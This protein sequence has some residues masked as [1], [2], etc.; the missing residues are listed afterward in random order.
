MLVNTAL[1]VRVGA[2][3][4]EISC[5]KGDLDKC[6]KKRQYFRLEQVKH[7]DQLIRF[8]TG[9]VSYPVFLSFFNFLGPV[10]NEL[11]Y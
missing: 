4:A 6:E 5:L 8:Y 10:M 1:L 11:H 7:D 2:L 9:F 3:E